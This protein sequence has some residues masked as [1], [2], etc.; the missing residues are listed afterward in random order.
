[1]IEK[2]NY[3]QIGLLILAWF[4][5]DLAAPLIIRFA[6][7]VGAV[8]RPRGYKIHREPV[9][10]LGG[11]VIYVAFSI[12]LFSI[13]RFENYRDH[14]DLFAIIFGGFFLLIVGAIDDFRPINAIVKLAILIVV[15]YLLSRFGVII[16][17]FGNE[18]GDLALTL[19]WIAGV[20]SAMNSLDNMDGA[21]TGIAAIAAFFTFYVAWYSD[22]PGVSY[23]AIA[24]LGACLGLLRYNFKPARIFLGDN[25]SFLLG[26]FLA[27]M[28]VLAG[29]AK[30]DTVK[31]IIVP[32]AILTVPLYDITLSTILRYKNGV[33]TS[34]K[35]A[36]LY[37]G[38]DHLSHRLVALGLSQ[39]EAVLMLYLFATVGGAIGVLIS[40]E[41]VGPE[42]YAPVVALSFVVLFVVG[43]LLDRARVYD[44]SWKGET[45]TAIVGG[46][47][48]E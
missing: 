47:K 37:C 45:P 38:Q 8:D 11:I 25:G 42:I 36:I 9:P 5:A 33:V 15:T 10:F 16:R 24:L 12:A 41:S 19:L 26:F 7:A 43:I 48:H 18:V 28:T 1:M 32:C 34:L 31:A 17:I 22:Q 29:W 35:D 30:K 23:V 14:Q 20:T 39:R 13:L 2:L 6:H 44:G 27:S 4:V 46:G 21:S 3:P 40:S